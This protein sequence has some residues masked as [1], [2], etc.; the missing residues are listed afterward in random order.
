LLLDV[1]KKPSITTMELY[2]ISNYFA[3]NTYIY[4]ISIR[5]Q[6]SEYSWDHSE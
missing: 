6:I 1:S 2:I 5:S 3:M 4:R